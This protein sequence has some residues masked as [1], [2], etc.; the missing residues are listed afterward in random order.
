MMGRRARG[1][2]SDWCGERDSR[3]SICILGPN[4]SNVPLVGA[5]AGRES[6]PVAPNSLKVQGAETRLE[7]VSV[8]QTCRGTGT[9]EAD[10]T[11]FGQNSKVTQVAPESRPKGWG[12]GVRPILENSTACRK[13]MPKYSI[14]PVHGIG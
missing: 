10:L 8:T 13:S 12:C 6:G 4:V 3:A 14:N 9:N 1:D 2:A 7:Q 5:S 11:G